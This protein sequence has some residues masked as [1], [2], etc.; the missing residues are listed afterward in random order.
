MRGEKDETGK[1]IGK[2]TDE[3]EK[4]KREEEGSNRDR[5]KLEREWNIEEKHDESRSYLLHTI[6]GV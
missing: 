3:E 4:E 5:N 6:Q 2:E 1:E